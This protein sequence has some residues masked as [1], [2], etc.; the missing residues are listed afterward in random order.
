MGEHKFYVT[1]YLY[2]NDSVNLRKFS[3]LKSANSWELHSTY[4]STSPLHCKRFPSC[5]YKTE[6]VHWGYTCGDPFTTETEVP[7][8]SA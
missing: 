2:I 8:Q 6:T 1:E 5:L 4:L 7:Q 3:Q